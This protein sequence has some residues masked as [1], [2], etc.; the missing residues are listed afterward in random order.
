MDPTIITL[1][2]ADGEAFVLE[3]H[4]A[5]RMG[6]VKTM[7]DL[8]EDQEVVPLP[9]VEAADL[10]KVIEFIQYHADLSR[11]PEEMHLW[12]S[13]FISVD[14]DALFHIML[15]ANYLDVEPLLALTT[16]KLAQELRGK[17]PDEIRTAFE[18]KN[19]LTPEEEAQVTREKGWIR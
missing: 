5:C 4:V 7:L 13:K 10:R 15:A 12:D 17:T 16:E 14:H 19:D 9:N 2:A 3:K 8:A 1:I 6:V 11:P 18:I